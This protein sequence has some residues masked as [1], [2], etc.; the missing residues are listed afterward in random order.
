MLRSCEE[1]HKNRGV[2][3]K[4]HRNDLKVQWNFTQLNLNRNHTLKKHFR[5]LQ[6]S[7]RHLER[8]SVYPEKKRLATF[9]P[10]SSLISDSFSDQE[11]VCILMYHCVALYNILLISLMPQHKVNRKLFIYR[12]VVFPHTNHTINCKRAGLFLHDPAVCFSNLVTKHTFTQSISSGLFG[13][14]IKNV[15]I[16]LF[17]LTQC[18]RVC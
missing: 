5:K 17:T 11:G 15:C 13:S 10:Q 4:D 8:H 16:H 14:I 1:G 2:H 18:P 6:S 7:Y 12:S 9:G 3:G